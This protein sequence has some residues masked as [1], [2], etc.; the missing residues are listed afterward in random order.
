MEQT[1]IQCGKTF[2]ATATQ[3]KKGYGKYC[4]RLCMGRWRSEHWKGENNPHYGASMDI[5]CPVCHKI[6]RISNSAKSRRRCCSN[7]CYGQY[8]SQNHVGENHSKW[9]G[10]KINAGTN[11]NYTAVYNPSHPRNHH[12]HVL[13]HIV[14]A[15]NMIGEPLPPGAVIHHI[16]GDGHDNTPSNLYI[17]NNQSEHKLFHLKQKREAQHGTK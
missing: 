9:K 6:F 17:F 7:A 12:G 3:I 15:E 13:E 5:T 10:G 1:C 11:G 2:N 8:K 16:N 14:I 4:S